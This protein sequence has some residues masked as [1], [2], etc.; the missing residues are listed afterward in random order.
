MCRG[1]QPDGARLSDSGGGG[2]AGSIDALNTGTG[3]VT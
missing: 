2:S 1:L 3:E